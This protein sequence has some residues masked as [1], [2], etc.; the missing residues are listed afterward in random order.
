VTFTFLSS[1]AI[2]EE[3]AAGVSAGSS[4]GGLLAIAWGDWVG[5]GERSGP[6]P[7]FLPFASFGFLASAFSLPAPA[8]AVLTAPLPTLN[9]PPRKPPPPPP[10]L[11]TAWAGGLELSDCVAMARDSTLGLA[12]DTR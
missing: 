10:P 6:E 3:D 8:S 5:A 12:P 1:K 11:L 4:A 9:K 2:G 7:P